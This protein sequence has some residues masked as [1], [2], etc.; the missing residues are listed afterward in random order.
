MGNR[1]AAYESQSDQITVVDAKTGAAVKKLKS[2]SFRKRKEF[3]G[4]MPL[5]ISPAGNLLAC[6]AE[7]AVVLYDIDAGKVVHKL[8]GHLDVV[9]AV[10]FSPNGDTVASAGKD[11]TIHFWNVKEG[12]AV[13]AIKNLPAGVSELLFSADGTRLAVMYH[14]NGLRGERQAEIRSVGL[15]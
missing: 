10:S 1:V 7:D 5:A 12:K 13:R 3:G 6:E 15:E 11:K 2:S 4:R 8:E 9:G 14:S